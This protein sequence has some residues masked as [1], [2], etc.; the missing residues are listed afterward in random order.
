MATVQEQTTRV[1]AR[2]P[3]WRDVR[4][5]RV[6]GQVVAVVVV[7]FFLRWLYNNLLD[8]LDRLGISPSFDFLYGPTNFQIPF[9]A[10]FDPRS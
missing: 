5:L 8:N 9:N 2:P 6:V 10:E 3:F 4:V 1:V 7:F